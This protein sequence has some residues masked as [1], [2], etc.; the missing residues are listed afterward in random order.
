MTETA[1]GEI[2]LQLEPDTTADHLI[3]RVT[4]AAAQ[5]L[6][7][8]LDE[9]GLPYSEV[10]ELS[11]PSAWMEILS[12]GLSSAGGW[13]TVREVVK[14]FVDRNK[15]KVVRINGIEAGGYSRKDVEALIDKV[16]EK[17]LE[18]EKLAKELR[19]ARQEQ[20]ERGAR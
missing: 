4:P 19:A 10:I 7:G 15:G 8:L 16:H 3:V 9:H 11:E 17:S 12:L 20:D 6:R 13:L 14:P 2:R 18:Q 1:E 5:E